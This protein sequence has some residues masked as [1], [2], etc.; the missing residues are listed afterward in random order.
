M[1]KLLW[2]LIPA[3]CVTGCNQVAK[4]PLGAAIMSAS[5]DNPAWYTSGL[6]SADIK[7]FKKNGVDVASALQ[8]QAAGITPA[9]TALKWQDA[10]FSPFGA[11]KLISADIFTP[12]EAA[13]WRKT[14][15]LD[16][17]VG[18]ISSDTLRAYKNAVDSGEV[19]QPEIASI[20]QTGKVS[21]DNTNF[22]IKSAALM[23]GGY[24]PQTAIDRQTKKIDDDKRYAFISTYGQ[25]VFNKCGYS[26]PHFPFSFVKV[27]PYAAQGKCFVLGISIYNK[28]TQW[29]NANELLLTDY[30]ALIISDEHVRIG[31][32]FIAIGETPQQYES[33]LGATQ[34]P[35]TLRILKY[36]N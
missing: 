31:H 23:K 5:G 15:N 28:N 32:D 1:K 34:T 27:D 36:L 22:V 4:D 26:I 18:G 35:V 20:L 2:S 11:K 25:E 29:V 6:S 12:Q 13:E 16:S 17:S 3:L 21:R 14:L 7:T 30:P 8:W 33:V 10:G 24:S 9:D 19:T